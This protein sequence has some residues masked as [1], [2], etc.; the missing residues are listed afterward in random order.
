MEVWKDVVGY[1]GYYQV[2]NRGQV[3][4]LPREIKRKNSRIYRTKL[5][6][7]KIHVSNRGY[8]A[9]RLTVNNKSR[10]HLVHRLVA[11]T[12]IE[13][14]ENKP[15]VNHID[16]NKTNNNLSNLEWTT[17][18]EN[19]HHSWEIGLSKPTKGMRHYSAK[20]D[21]EKVVYIRKAFKNKEKSIIE[22]AEIFN[23]T[24]QSVGAVINRKTWRHIK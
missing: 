2:S 14:R 8:P 17:P 22:L 24:P 15:Y 12:F 1:E 11:T 21:D 3:K 18:T 9:V 16:G 7:M 20:L 4:S 10:V 13:N 23:I 5:K 19:S 6:L